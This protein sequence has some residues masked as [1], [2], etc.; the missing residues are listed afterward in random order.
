[1]LQYEVKKSKQV[2]TMIKKSENEFTTYQIFHSFYFL[3]CAKD[4]K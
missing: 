1:M 2:D 3:C 4:G